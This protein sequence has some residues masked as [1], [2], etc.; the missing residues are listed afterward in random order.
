M[1]CLYLPPAP[2]P[3]LGYNKPT[4]DFYLYNTLTK[5]REKFEPITPGKVGLYTC[6]PT[7]YNF[8]HIGN[9]RTFLFEDLLVRVLRLN[10]FAVTHV[11][12]ITDVGHMTTDADS[13]EDKMAVAARRENLDPY[14]IARK[15]EDAFVRDLRRLNINR[16]TE[17]PR[18]TEHVAEMV[19]LNKSLEDK[20][21]TYTTPEG[22]YFDTSKVADYGKLAR[23]NLAGQIEGARE[24]V[25]TDALKRNPADF[26]LW[27]TNKPTHIMQWDS[28]WG[29]G[30][31]GWHI[32]CSAMSMKYLGKTFDI[33]CGGIDHI[34]VHNTN[35]IAQSESATG[36]TFARFWMHAAFL[37]MRIGGGGARKMAKSGGGFVQ[38]Q[39]LIDSGYDPLAY[40]YL[41]LQAHYRS[42]LELAWKWNGDD[43]STGK[44]RA[45]SLDNAAIGLT[46]LY[47]RVSRTSDEP[48][49]TDEGFQGAY[50]EVLGHL[51]DD[52]NLPRALG[53]LYTYGSPRLW[54]AFDP[55]LGLDFET[56]AA[57][58]VED[59]AP[60]AV[61]S[62]VE[63][64]QA[65]RQARDFPLSDRLRDEIAALGWEIADTPGG[66][67][68]KRK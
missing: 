58:R 46:R 68:L 43:A 67:T 52:L 61:Q 62:L 13:G 34:P 28:P 15:Y 17:L 31:P 19:A 63:Q 11:M 14:A 33:H 42:E 53:T 18:A 23:L 66:A 9:L 36:Q 20:G 39:T 56:R 51:N 64:R 10:G 50:N 45:E 16:P 30:Y 54:T 3:L 32:E 21:F 57:K 22:L 6:G 1:K 8:A 48:L 25:N 44:G 29:V 38:V 4:M 40:R 49:T 26:I 27:F 2:P 5:S 59:P 37:N 47:E 55:V 65:A 24:D 12:N 35:E 7:V 41:C 60:D